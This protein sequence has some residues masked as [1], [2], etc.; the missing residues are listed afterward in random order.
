MTGDAS[1]KQTESP[2]WYQLSRTPNPSLLR[3]IAIPMVGSLRIELPTSGA[4]P[5][6]H[7][8]ERKNLVNS[9]WLSRYVFAVCLFSQ[10]HSD[11]KKSTMYS[12][13]DIMKMIEFLFDNIYTFFSGKSNGY[14]LCPSS[15]RHLSVFIRS[16]IHTVFA[17]NGKETASWFNL[18]YMYIDD[19]LSID[20]QE[21]ENYMGQMYSVELEVKGTTESITSTSYLYLLLSIRGWS[22]SHF[23][24]WQTRLFKFP[25]HKLSVPE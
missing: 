3:K 1:G 8:L 7:S 4:S 13:N 17:R 24:S 25:H 5:E 22:T 16:A 20:N 18:T 21:I 23:N 6:I 10:E 12:E 14:K 9:I 2:E 19:K 15:H 11:S